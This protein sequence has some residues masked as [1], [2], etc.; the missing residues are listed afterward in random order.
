MYD[1]A[2]GI[3]LNRIDLIETYGYV[4]NGARAYYP[5]SCYS[6]M[7]DHQANPSLLIDFVE[8]LDRL[9]MIK[10]GTNLMNVKL[11]FSETTRGDKLPVDKFL[12]ARKAVADLDSSDVSTAQSK[13]TCKKYHLELEVGKTINALDHDVLAV[14]HHM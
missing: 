12:L 6:Y 9:L 8:S 5:I 11:R 10:S 2:K 1:T 7:A 14:F 3:V 13:G 4:L